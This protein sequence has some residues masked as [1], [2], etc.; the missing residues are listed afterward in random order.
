MLFL[1]LKLQL[2]GFVPVRTL[3]LRTDIRFPLFISRYPFVIAPLATVGPDGPFE[4]RH[5][6]TIL[7]QVYYRQAK[8]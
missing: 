6:V 3:T 8:I 7:L 2:P 4:L 5:E 1:S